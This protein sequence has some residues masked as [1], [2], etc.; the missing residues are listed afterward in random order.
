M[1]RSDGTALIALVDAGA[2]LGAC[3]S[4]PAMFSLPPRGEQALAAL[5]RYRVGE[6]SG[7]F[8]GSRAIFSALIFYMS[9]DP[10]AVAGL[11]NFSP[12]AGPTPPAGSLAGALRR[13]TI[14]RLPAPLTLRL[15]RLIEIANS[16]TGQRCSRTAV[17]VSLM[18]Q[19]RR[20]DKDL[21]RARFTRVLGEPASC[22]VPA[23]DAASPETVLRLIRP[24]PGPR[25]Q[26]VVVGSD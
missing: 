24:R 19:A 13:R 12:A 18:R 4:W 22:A 23:S 1:P 21:W 2:P 15:N 9:E 10:E 14:V 8:A 6:A 7:Q 20:E 5:R 3:E 26:H 16:E 11:S 17:M 25:P